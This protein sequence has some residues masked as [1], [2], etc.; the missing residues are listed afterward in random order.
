ME[1]NLYDIVDIKKY[2]INNLNFKKIKNL[3]KKCRK[4]L[5]EF[6][7]ATIPSFILPKY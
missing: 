3:I 1:K 6:S 4:D 2:P 5:N 7:C